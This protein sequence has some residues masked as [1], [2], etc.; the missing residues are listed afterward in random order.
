MLREPIETAPSFPGFPFSPLFPQANIRLDRKHHTPEK[1]ARGLERMGS[2]IRSLLAGAAF[3]MLVI[4]CGGVSGNKGTT[5]PNGGPTPTPGP[6]PAGIT[7]VN[8]V[9][10]LIQENRSFDHYFG[11]MTAYR[12]ANNIPITGSPATI[13]DE[14]TGTFSNFSPATGTMIAAYHTGSVCTSMAMT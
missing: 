3:A 7:A 9:V 14:S 13:E 10:I 2:R 4:G 12:K 5:P 8:H 11:Q 6:A 1:E